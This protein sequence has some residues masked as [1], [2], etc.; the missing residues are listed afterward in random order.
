MK[1]SKLMVA[2]AMVAT[3]SA[4]VWALSSSANK[5]MMHL[6]EVTS[7]AVDSD[8][9]FQSRVASLNIANYPN[10]MVAVIGEEIPAS[11]VAALGASVREI[12]PVYYMEVTVNGTT[13][14]QG[15]ILSE[16]PR[17]MA[18]FVPAPV[19]GFTNNLVE[20]HLLAKDKHGEVLCDRE[21]RGY[22]AP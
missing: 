13:Y 5:V 9:G 10:N 2:L 19:G 7:P 22:W 8:Y 12:R 15:V 6:P 11:T 20:Y 4:G 3:L 21:I 17:A 16:H 14:N 18:V 1:K